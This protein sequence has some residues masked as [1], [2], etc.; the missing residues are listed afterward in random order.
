MTKAIIDISA[1]T[2]EEA[3]Q[4]AAL[5]LG[6][7]RDEIDYEVVD[8][9]SKGLLGFIGT[10]DAQIRAW[11]KETKASLVLDF[12][13]PIFAKLGVNPDYKEE[14]KDGIFWM[15]FSGTGMGRMIGRRGETLDALQYLTNLAVNGKREEKI[16]IVLD[17]EGYRQSREETLAALAHK[18]ADRAKKSGRSIAL[19]P[20]SPHERRIIHMALQNEKGIQ[21]LSEGEEPARRVIIA[22]KHR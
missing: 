15:S 6:V 4:K 10:K 22:P 2:V 8:S 21:T 18:M 14:E 13:E 17:V 16:R 7:S 19:E 5:E 12:L 9:G 1:K 11:K 3:I 20:M